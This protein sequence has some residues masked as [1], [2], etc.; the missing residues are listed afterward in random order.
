MLD[1]T[2]YRLCDGARQ[3]GTLFKREILDGAEQSSML[4]GSVAP[5]T[6][7][8]ESNVTMLHMLVLPSKLKKCKDIE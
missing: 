3:T 5:H 1:R 2:R 6:V 7:A 4:Y 8:T